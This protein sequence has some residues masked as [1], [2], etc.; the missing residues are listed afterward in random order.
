MVYDIEDVIPADTSNFHATLNP[1]V[2]GTTYGNGRALAEG[3]S[4]VM[5]TRDSGGGY[6]DDV[7]DRSVM[8]GV[9]LNPDHDYAVFGIGKY[10]NLC[11]PDG[12]VKEAPI[13]GQHKSQTSPAEEYQR[14]C[15]VYDIGPADEDTSKVNAKFIGVVAIAGKRLFTAGDIAGRYRDNEFSL[16]QPPE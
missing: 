7:F 2:A 15:A 14:F 5:L 11:G 1:Y 12:V 16:T 3:E 10:C 8:P 6:N 4:V 9:I 13:H